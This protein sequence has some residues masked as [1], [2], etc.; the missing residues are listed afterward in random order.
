MLDGCRLPAMALGYSFD[1]FPS[2]SHL[3][4]TS[5]FIFI[6][7]DN[8][9]SILSNTALQSPPGAL[10]LKMDFRSIQWPQISNNFSVK[11]P[12]YSNNAK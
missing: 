6:A 1:G 7:T 5:H 4:K 9:F 2:V 11:L 12:H 3:L 10:M 8:Y